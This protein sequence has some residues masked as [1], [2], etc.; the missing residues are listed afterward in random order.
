VPL[1]GKVQ[2]VMM[3]TAAPRC[4]PLALLNLLAGRSVDWLVMSED[5]PAPGNR[6]IVD[7]AGRITTARR[8]PW[9]GDPS[10]PPQAGEAAAAR[11]ATTC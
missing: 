11:P 7:S 4:V 9:H 1:I 8:R 2:G 3:Q 10:P 5:L 6:V